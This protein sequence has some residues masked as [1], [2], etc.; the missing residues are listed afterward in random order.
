M[1]AGRETS[2]SQTAPTG[3]VVGWSWE[4][5]GCKLMCAV[6]DLRRFGDGNNSHT[7]CGPNF[8]AFISFFSPYHW[9]PIPSPGSGSGAAHHPS[10]PFYALCSSYLDS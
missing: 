3:V 2:L 4:A 10:L 8:N 5:V 6:S 7:T 1:L 9:R